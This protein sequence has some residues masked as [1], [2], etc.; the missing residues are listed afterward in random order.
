[1]S[2][3]LIAAGGLLADALAAE[4]AALAALDLS[5][6]AG[7]LADKQRI[8]AE[9][10]A[11]AQGAAQSRQ[12]VEQMARRLQALAIEN[13]S[14]LERAMAV[15]GRVISVVARA[16]TPAA[17]STGYGASRHAASRPVAIALSARA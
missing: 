6:A 7:M 14:L 17:T 3:D 5:R 10:A 2:T 16:A 4:N 9:F 11:A 8:A 13:K 12:A 15:Q 1:M